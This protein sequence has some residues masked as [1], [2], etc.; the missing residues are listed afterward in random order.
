MTKSSFKYSL[1]GVTNSAVKSS[2]AALQDYSGVTIVT[3]MSWSSSTQSLTLPSHSLYV[4][5]YQFSTRYSTF[6]SSQANSYTFYKRH[7]L[8]QQTG[9]RFPIRIDY[10]H[11]AITSYPTKTKYIMMAIPLPVPCN[12]MFTMEYNVESAMYYQP[13]EVKLRLG[14]IGN[15]GFI[16]WS[17]TW[18]CSRY[19]NSLGSRN[20]V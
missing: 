11:Q 4:S 8:P 14:F 12:Y 19:Y 13:N 15:P 17:A 20:W 16:N 9:K 6:S 7:Q 5:T 2:W 18:K 3:P 10:V 1:V